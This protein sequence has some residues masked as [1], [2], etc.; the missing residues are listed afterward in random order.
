MYVSAAAQQIEEVAKRLPGTL[1]GVYKFE[2]D[3]PNDAR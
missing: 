3:I 1:T 2:K